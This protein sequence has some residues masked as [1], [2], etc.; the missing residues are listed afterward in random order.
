MSTGSWDPQ[1][2]TLQAAQRIDDALL[3]RFLA[4][5][6]QGALD[7]LVDAASAEDCAQAQLMQAPLASWDAALEHYS[8]VELL[9]L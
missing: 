6:A 8:E 3:R 5:E 2:G 7:K 9:A 4:L 1:K